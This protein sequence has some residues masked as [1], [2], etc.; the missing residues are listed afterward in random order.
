MIGD[1]SITE[2]EEQSRSAPD[3]ELKEP[4][5]HIVLNEPEIPNNTGSIGRTCVGLNMKLWLVRPLGF[6]I[7]DHHLRRAGLDYWPNLCWEAV[8]DWNTLEARLRES[9]PDRP[10]RYWFFSKKARK[11]YSDTVFCRGDIFV[12]GRESVGLPESFLFEHQEQALRIPISDKIRSLNV[13]VAA[14]IV[15]F[16]AYRQ[17][18]LQME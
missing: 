17:V 4:L 3:Q 13:A 8:D 18:T 1:E 11:V 12:F 15:A 16:E 2:E 9:L 6:H 10:L 7:T 5:F 14:G